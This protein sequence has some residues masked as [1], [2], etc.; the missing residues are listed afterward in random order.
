MVIIKVEAAE[1]SQQHQKDR[2][3]AVSVRNSLDAIEMA[4]LHLL[5]NNLNT[6]EMITHNSKITI[7]S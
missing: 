4:E 6:K 3:I 2:V 5:L 7:K 1:H